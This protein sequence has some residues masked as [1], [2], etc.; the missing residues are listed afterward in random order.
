MAVPFPVQASTFEIGSGQAMVIAIMGHPDSRGQPIGVDEEVW[1]YGLSTV[2]FRDRYVIGW[3]NRGKNLRV[4]LG[5]PQKDPPQVVEGVSWRV[6]AEA[7]GTPESITPGESKGVEAWKYGATIIT[8]IDGVVVSYINTTPD[9]P[10]VKE[11]PVRRT[12]PL[13]FF[14]LG[15]SSAKVQAV[16]GKPGSRA[17]FT[18]VNEEVWSWGESTVTLKNDTVIG[19]TNVNKKLTVFLGFERDSAKSLDIGSS[20]QEVVNALGTPAEIIPF[21]GLAMELWTYGSGK[22]TLCKGQVWSWNNLSFRFVKNRINNCPTPPEN[23]PEDSVAAWAHPLI[24]HSTRIPPYKRGDTFPTTVMRD[25]RGFAWPFI[26]EDGSYY[27]QVSELTGQPKTVF[28]AGFYLS[29]KTYVRSHYR[30]KAAP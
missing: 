14:R 4:F 26:A 19:W 15:S 16:M 6:V 30:S 18:N 22:V 24:I 5:M 7:L 17:T 29:D 10:E 12:P 2:T 3:D 27:R 21:T 8:L 9:I 25:E 1:V 11:K 20:R 13:K 28:V 23:L